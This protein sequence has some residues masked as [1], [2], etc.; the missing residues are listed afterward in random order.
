MVW[1]TDRE[2]V[3]R[4]LLG[5]KVLRE[6]LISAAILITGIVTCVVLD[7]TFPLLGVS[8][9]W[10]IPVLL[11]FAFGTAR[12]LAE[13]LE[14]A[15]IPA[16]KNLAVVGAVATGLS[17]TIPWLWPL[18]GQEYPAN[19]PVGRLGWIS[20]GAMCGVALVFAVEMRNYGSGREG[21]IQRILSTAMASTYVGIPIAFILAI[22]NLGVEANWGI[23]AVV[24]YI[25]VTKAAD[26]GAY[27]VGRAVGKHKMAPLL[28]PGKTWEG[29]A[30][31]IIFSIAASYLCLYLGFPVVCEQS[32]E[33]PV[34]GPPTLGICCSI[35]GMFGDLAE[36]Y[37]KR[38][39]GV[40]DSGG[41]LPGMGGVW[42]VTDSPIAAAVP[43][44]L[45]FALGVAGPVS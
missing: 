19:C 28:S 11:F 36:S 27:F 6:R 21:G 20:I 37:M 35:A 13:L 4:K 23:A 33:I 24:T 14:H 41:L 44:F 8:G 31:G 10:L 15:G 18:V 43:G 26:S 16:N 29:A 5:C 7:V 34:W 3:P 25:A 32:L 9:L 12:E 1:S 40:K 22:R 17:A 39:S 42:D 45:C 30:G 38:V 2:Q